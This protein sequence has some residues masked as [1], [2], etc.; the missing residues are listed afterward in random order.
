[1]STEKVYNR[2]RPRS[3]SA[4]PYEA[5]DD[6][7][8]S[9]Q[10]LSRRCCSAVIALRFSRR[11]LVAL[12]HCC[13]MRDD[14]ALT[15]RR[16]AHDRQQAIRIRSGGRNARHGDASDLM[17]SSAQTV[18]PLRDG[19]SGM[20]ISQACAK[21]PTPR[22][23]TNSEVRER[24]RADAKN[25]F[26]WVEWRR[27]P[28][29]RDIP[30]IP[31]PEKLAPLRFDAFFDLPPGRWAIKMNWITRPPV[32]TARRNETSRITNDERNRSSHPGACL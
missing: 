1:M 11:F 7:S 25:F 15:T 3:E 32:R 8:V 26:G 9:P 18:P 16:R 29:A 6:R 28:H 14:G 27:I 24:R 4:F 17:D 12:S 13:R 31:P 22:V 10:S 30:R 21:K 23:E 5:R 2:R 19:T 20:H